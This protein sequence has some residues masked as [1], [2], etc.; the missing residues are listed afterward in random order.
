[1]SRETH[2]QFCEGLGVQLLGAT[3]PG[4][5]FRATHGHEVSSP[6]GSHP[7]ALAELYVSLSTHTAPT[8]EPRRT[9]ICQ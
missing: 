6:G 5:R 2:V 8:M 9:P 1:M 4:R 3:H 7:E